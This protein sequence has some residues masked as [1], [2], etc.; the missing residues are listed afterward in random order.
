M[1]R[2]VAHREAVPSA[3]AP[4]P[5]RLCADACR[6][7]EIASA[8]IERWHRLQ[9]AHG[10]TTPFLSP[11][12]AIAVDAVDP[13]TRGGVLS[14]GADHIGFRSSMHRRWGQSTAHG[15]ANRQAIVGSAAIAWNIPHAVRAVGIAHWEFDHLVGA[16]SDGVRAARRASAATIE[17]GRGFE[18]HVQPVRPRSKTSFKMIE[19]RRRQLGDRFPGGS[20]PSTTP[21]TLMRVRCSLAGTL[22]RF[23]AP[24]GSVRTPG[25]ASADGAHRRQSHP[26]PCRMHLSAVR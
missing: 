6:P 7:S 1:T 19:V 23:G 20:G 17:T 21:V 4:A 3:S 18:W 10:L 14:D 24:E 26:V 8:D 16:Q 9:I 13:S 22:R 2:R 5:V 11:E 15:Y 12:S 25:D